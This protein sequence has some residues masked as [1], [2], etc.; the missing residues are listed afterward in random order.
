[1]VREGKLLSGELCDAVRMLRRRRVVFVHRLVSRFAVDLPG[2]GVDEALH[3]GLQHRVAEPCRDD[4]IYFRRKR[5]SLSREINIA[6]CCEM[7]D[8]V[9]TLHSFE[10]CH[11]IT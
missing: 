4:R 6:N 8:E 10:E 1:M 9:R 2:G 7:A 11:F 3:A 5:R